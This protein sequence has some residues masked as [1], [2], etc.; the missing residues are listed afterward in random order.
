MEFLFL[1]LT[2]SG[3]RSISVISN[4]PISG[5]FILAPSGCKF[6]SRLSIESMQVR[7]VSLGRGYR[8]KGG[9]VSSIVRMPGT[10]IEVRVSKVRRGLLSVHSDFY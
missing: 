5:D 7:P 6:G 2:L 10:S 1:Y 3:G 4:I 9:S 8:M